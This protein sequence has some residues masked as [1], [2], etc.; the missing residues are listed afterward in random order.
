MN[1]TDPFETHNEPPS[2][3]QLK[4]DAL[5]LQTLGSELLELPESDWIALGLPQALITALRDGKRIRAHGA[6]RRQ[7]Q[8]IGKLMRDIDAAPVR[9]HF[10]QLRLKSREQARAHQQLEH[11]RERLI[12]QGDAAVEAFLELHTGADRQQLRQ[13]VRKAR[14]ERDQGQPPAA[15]RALFRYL[16]ELSDGSW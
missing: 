4:R 6:R 13:L 15:S 7:L 9:E 3:S 10:E 16:R 14:K 5:A 2:K 12:E 11:W 1:D 8:Y